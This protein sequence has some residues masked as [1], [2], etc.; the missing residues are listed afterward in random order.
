MNARFKL[1]HEGR[2]IALCESI[3]DAMI[4]VKV[5]AYEIRALKADGTE[6][7]KQEEMFAGQIANSIIRDWRDK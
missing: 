4:L 3:Y 6:L 5:H 7:N 1:E 2:T